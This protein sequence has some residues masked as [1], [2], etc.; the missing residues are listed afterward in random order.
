MTYKIKDSDVV[1]TTLPHQ[2]GVA[3]AT[4]EEGDEV[5]NVINTTIQE[6]DDATFAMIDCKDAEDVSRAEFIQRADE[7]KT[8]YGKDAK[9]ISTGIKKAK[10]TLINTKDKMMIELASAAPNNTSIKLTKQA[11]EEEYQKAIA[12][13]RAEKD[14]NKKNVN[15]KSR[16]VQ[17]KILKLTRTTRDEIST[18]TTEALDSLDITLATVLD[19]SAVAVRSVVEGSD[20]DIMIQDQIN[21]YIQS[22]PQEMNDE[23]TKFAKIFYTDNETVE[24]YI[25]EVARTATEIGDIQE[26]LEKEVNRLA[27]E[28]V[29]RNLGTGNQ[30]KEMAD[31]TDNEEN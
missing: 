10:Q 20:F 18:T 8:A 22:Y 14:R 7:F 12:E 19:Q 17:D 31:P 5:T 4:I 28:W 25:R 30:F 16:S 29:E 13:V 26:Q 9:A 6:V 2:I 23:M 24:H 15:D 3:R 21:N 11:I 1:L 27:T